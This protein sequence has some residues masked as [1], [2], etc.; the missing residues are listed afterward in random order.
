M[1]CATVTGRA[2]ARLLLAACAVTLVGCGWLA[3]GGFEA[4]RPRWEPGV[5]LDPH[6]R[7]EY[8]RGL[9]RVIMTL[10]SID[11]D[12]RLHRALLEALPDYSEVTLLVPRE[13]RPAIER[14]LSSVSHGA[15]VRVQPYERPTASW[16]AF[17][18]L[19]PDKNLLIRVPADDEELANVYGTRW[20]QDLFE[21]VTDARAEHV[22]L[23]TWVQ[24]HLYDRRGAH[25]RA[26]V[27]DTRFLDE[28]T[29]AGLRLHVIPLA[30]NG[31]NLFVDELNGRKLA[32]VG[33]D[34]LRKTGTL[35]RSFGEIEP[36][37]QSFRQQLESA[38]GVDDVVLVGGRAPQPDLM[39]H[40]DQALV[41]LPGGVAGV[42]RLVDSGAQ[43]LASAPAVEAVRRFLDELRHTLSELGYRLVDIEMTVE[44]L[45]AYRHP[46]NVIPFIDAKTGQR[47]LLVPVYDDGRSDQLANRR[48][49]NVVFE[50]LDFE[51]TEVP[52]RAGELKGGLHCLVNVID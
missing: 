13:R 42:V 47:R 11:K 1:S 3:R 27:A 14:A 10:G 25:P 44:D 50:E 32:L 17:F 37:E 39:Y 18:L 6:S 12:L 2:A 5:V 43:R 51:V 33:A 45:V 26:G 36:S 40:L 9:R 20:A 49:R 19:R 34:A 23:A 22:L 4:D 16:R 35:A 41:L 15:R 21:V 46:I 31:G 29:P 30:F 8:D 28:L 7:P 38:L 48:R 52:T 24:R